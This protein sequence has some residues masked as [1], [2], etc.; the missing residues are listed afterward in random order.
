MA[1]I[2]S[3]RDEKSAIEGRNAR[4]FGISVQDVAS[5]K[6]FASSNNVNFPLLADD[7]MEAATAYGVLN[8]PGGYARRVTFYIDPAGV[9]RKIDEKIRPFTAGKDVAATLKALQKPGPAPAPKPKVLKKK[10]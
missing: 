8:R 9:I 5:K 2:C 10:R 3:L 4:V 6:K 7:R 1:E